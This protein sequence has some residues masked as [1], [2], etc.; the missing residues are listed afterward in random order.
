MVTLHIAVTAFVTNDE[1]EVLLTKVQWR[2]DTWELPGGQVEEEEALDKAV[3]REVLKETG[4][5][6]K[7]I[8]IT[9]VYYNSTKQN[10]VVVFKAKYITGE[11][12]VPPEE[13]NEAKF[14][15]LN[16]KNINQ[17][18]T[19]PHMQSRVLD[20]MNAKNTIPYETWEVSPYNLVGRLI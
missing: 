7:P 8:G 12:K 20:A 6:T 13:I 2:L 11:I 16:E 4:L 14:V 17:N 15:E 10:L 18:I 5:V 1:N 3:A 19:R 9:G